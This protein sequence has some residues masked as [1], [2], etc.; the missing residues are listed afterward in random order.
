MDGE[1]GESTKGEDVVV[2][3]KRKVTDRQTEMRLTERS[4]N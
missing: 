1:S 4:R 3:G 2:A